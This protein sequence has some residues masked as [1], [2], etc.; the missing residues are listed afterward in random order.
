VQPRGARTLFTIYTYVYLI[1]KGFWQLIEAKH[2][3]EELFSSAKFTGKTL[4]IFLT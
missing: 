1:E 2:P 4:Q 3:D